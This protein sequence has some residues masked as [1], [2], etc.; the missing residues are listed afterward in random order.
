MTDL[1]LGQAQVQI[2]F[3]GLRSPKSSPVFSDDR[4]SGELGQPLL[5]S[6]GKNTIR[7]GYSPFCSQDLSVFLRPNASVL[8]LCS[9][10][11]LA[12]VATMLLFGAFGCLL[13]GR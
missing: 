13:P 12:S 2:E 8:L 6:P 9:R 7:V 1:P 3:S 4:L 10:S 11:W 5:L